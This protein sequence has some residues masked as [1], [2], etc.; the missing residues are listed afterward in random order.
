MIIIKKNYYLFI[1]NFKSLNLEKFKN[2]KKINIILRNTKNNN[3]AEIIK[4]RQ[5]CK[6]K[7]IKFYIANNIKIANLCRADGLYISAYNKKKYYIN[8]TKIG[9]AHNLK[10]INEKI[11]QDCEVIIFSRLF[12][13]QYLHKKD[14]LGVLKFN[15]FT[16]TINKKLIPLGGINNQNLLKLNLINCDGFAILSAVKKK[17]TISSRLF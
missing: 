11:Y 14:W 1:E 10:E 12:Q 5:K 17:P 16:K 15:F 6:S 8:I 9:S 2:N 13:T 7:R 3:L 4:F